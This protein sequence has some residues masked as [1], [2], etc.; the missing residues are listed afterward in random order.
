M[1]FGKVYARKIQDDTLHLSVQT[2]PVQR[3]QQGSQL[4]LLKK[5]RPYC[6]P[7]YIYF[8]NEICNLTR[9]TFSH[10][11]YFLCH[12]CCVCVMLGQT[13]MYWRHWG[14]PIP[15]LSYQA[16]RLTVTIINTLYYILIRHYFYPEVT[17]DGHSSLT[18]KRC[19]IGTRPW[20]GN[21]ELTLK[22]IMH[23]SR[24]QVMVDPPWL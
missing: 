5:K 12:C 1:N 21:S 10:L 9:K 8:C 7:I 22:I 20:P 15:L 23:K 3:Q 2:I 4:A 18:T 14:F 24:T 13:K 11:G 16:I 6:L 19:K 17:L